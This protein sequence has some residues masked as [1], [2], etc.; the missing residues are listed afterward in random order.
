MG[1][2]G[3]L[4]TALLSPFSGLL[5]GPAPKYNKANF[6]NQVDLDELDHR[7]ARSPEELRNMSLEG[8]DDAAAMQGSPDQ[9]HAEKTALGSAGGDDISGALSRRSSKRFG[10]DLSRLKR[11]AD[12]ESVDR[13][14]KQKQTAFDANQAKLKM[15]MYQDQMAAYAEAEQEAARYSVLSSLMGGVG[16][17]AGTGLAQA[18]GKPKEGA[19]NG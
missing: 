7:S 11:Q 19:K 18:M 17:F 10:N 6:N 12:V 4:G 14:Y 2:L 16:T 9:I 15:D 1:L 5:A 8:T 13:K 3:T